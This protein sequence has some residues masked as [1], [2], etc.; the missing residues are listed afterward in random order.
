[1]FEEED[2]D[3]VEEIITVR[4]L[5]TPRLKQIQVHHAQRHVASPWCN[6]HADSGRLAAQPPDSKREEASFPPII[7]LNVGGHIYM[8][9][10]ST[11]L[12]Y[13]DS[14]LAAMFSGR[15][16]IDRDN[17]GNY[18]L[19]SNGVIF[20]HILEFLRY[21]SLPDKENAFLVYRDA[22]Y[23][24]LHELVEKLALRPEIAAISVKEAHKSQFPNYTEVKEQVIR[25]AMANASINRV[26][27]VNIYA[28]RKEFKAKAPSFSL[29]HTCV[30]EQ[31]DIAVG[32]WEAAADEE[33]F[34]RCLENDLL[35]EGFIVRPHE[36]KRRCK[37]YNGQTCQKF[38]FKISI[39][40]D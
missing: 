15:H 18:F 37:Y 4:P 34:I 35:E 8:T 16:R 33:T 22:H 39:S 25:T 10:L 38:L 11:L 31:A 13:S 19:D 24:G 36:A 29:K 1:M 7:P 30:T 12:K 3:T 28:F 14:M 2:S 17:N 40:F 27:D 6:G 5:P 32:P 9:R 20:S 23:Y 26:G 21:G